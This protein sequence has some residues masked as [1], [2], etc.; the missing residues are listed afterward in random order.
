MGDEDNALNIRASISFSSLA[1]TSIARLSC[2]RVLMDDMLGC[3]VGG[4]CGQRSIFRKSATE[5]AYWKTHRMLEVAQMILHTMTSTSALN[6]QLLTFHLI[7]VSCKLL[8]VSIIMMK[9]GTE[10]SLASRSPW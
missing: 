1:C 5:D 4:P 10:D 9:L 6:C 8:F 2:S 3:K 7:I